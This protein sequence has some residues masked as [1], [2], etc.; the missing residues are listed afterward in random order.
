MVLPFRLGDF[1][2]KGRVSYASLQWFIL[3][4][5]DRMLDMGFGPDIAKCMA[6]PTMPDKTV[7]NTLMFSATF[8]SDVQEKAREYLRKVSSYPKRNLIQGG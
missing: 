8:A 1:V 4:E 7:R 3:D 6:H 2:E 5:A